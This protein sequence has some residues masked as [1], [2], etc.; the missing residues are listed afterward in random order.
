MTCR[1]LLALVTY[2]QHFRHYLLGRHFELRTDH[3]FLTWLQGFKEPEGQLA[4]WR[5]RLQE[6]N[7]KIIHHCGKQHRNADALSR[8]PRQQ[9]G[10][11]HEGGETESGDLF[12]DAKATNIGHT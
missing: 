8:R 9:C 11:T 4:R 3:G 7:L 2:V 5:E 10:R 12:S 6:F 1:E